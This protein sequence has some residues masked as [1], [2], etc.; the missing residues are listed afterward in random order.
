MLLVLYTRRQCQGLQSDHA[1]AFEKGNI[2]LKNNKEYV[3]TD[4]EKHISEKEER[5]KAEMSISNRLACGQHPRC[6]D[7]RPATKLLGL[8]I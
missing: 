8:F 7:H 4:H 5:H 1:T 2:T 3:K 6:T